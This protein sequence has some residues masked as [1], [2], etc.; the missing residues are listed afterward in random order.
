[1]VKEGVQ[2]RLKAGYLPSEVDF[3]PE[4]TSRELLE[5]HAG[6]YGIE[7]GEKRIEELAQYFELAFR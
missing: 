7:K 2:A 1:M 5:Y 4:M 6:L 3:Y